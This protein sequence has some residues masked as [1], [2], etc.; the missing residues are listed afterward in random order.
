MVENS[1]GTSSI[2]A[3][4]GFGE[5]LPLKVGDSSGVAGVRTTVGTGASLSQAKGGGGVLRQPKD[6]KVSAMPAH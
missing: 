1:S 6:N 2:D 3:W 5:R 4:K